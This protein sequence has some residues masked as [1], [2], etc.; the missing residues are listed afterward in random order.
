MKNWEEQ[1]K[2]PNKE[3]DVEYAYILKSDNN[4]VKSDKET[5]LDLIENNKEIKYVTTPQN[6][7]YIII[8]RV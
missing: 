7:T 6:D 4:P 3:S 2:L 5:L 1:I 8:G